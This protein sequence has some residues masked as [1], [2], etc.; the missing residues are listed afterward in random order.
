MLISPWL[1][2]I[3]PVFQLVFAAW[4]TVLWSSMNEQ[5]YLT[6]PEHRSEHKGPQTKTAETC[7][8]HFDLDISLL[9]VFSFWPLVLLFK[10]YV[11][12]AYIAA[13]AGLCQAVA[14]ISSGG[15][16]ANQIQ[17]LLVLRSARLKTETAGYPNRSSCFFPAAFIAAAAQRCHN[18]S[19]QSI[20]AATGLPT[21][22]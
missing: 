2:L 18:S 16:Q 1:S 7:R 5:C 4:G 8:F 6:Y 17:S 22:D 12:L 10:I 20:R 11:I 3:Q 9:L 15:A 21:E 19:R 13:I 14:L